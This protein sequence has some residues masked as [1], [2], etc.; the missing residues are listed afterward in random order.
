LLNLLLS[1]AEKCFS[2]LATPWAHRLVFCAFEHRI[3]HA[4]RGNQ[5]CSFGFHHREILRVCVVSMFDGVDARRERVLNS[6]GGCG[7]GCHL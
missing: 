1:V 5:K 2:P 6:F 3:D 4:N 7:V